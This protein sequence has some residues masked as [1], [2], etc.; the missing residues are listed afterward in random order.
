MQHKT[1]YS[2]FCKFTLHVSG[3]NHTH[4][5]DTW[6]CNYSLRYW[7]YFLC[8]YLQRARSHKHKICRSI[9]ITNF[10]C[11]YLEVNKNANLQKLDQSFLTYKFTHFTAVN[12][13]MLKS[14]VNF[15]LYIIC[16][17]MY[18]NFQQRQRNLTLNLL[19]WKIWWAPNNTSRW[20]VGF[21]SAFKGL[22]WTWIN[23]TASIAK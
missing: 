13:P 16:N 14:I 12:S 7:S 6:N 8:S 21:N 10:M 4:Y 22:N 18:Y 20:Q 11:I 1:V 23:V 17:K 15:L 19:T 2:L 9:T 5:Q 3:V